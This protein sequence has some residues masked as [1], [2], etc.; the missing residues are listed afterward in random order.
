MYSYR[1]YEHLT[2]SSSDDG[3]SSV[4]CTDAKAFGVFLGRGAGLV[5]GNPVQILS[6]NHPPSL[7]TKVRETEDGWGG[8]I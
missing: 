7:L 2:K 8:G 1:M 6:N 5:T 3:H 4:L